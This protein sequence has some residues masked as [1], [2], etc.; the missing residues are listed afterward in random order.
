MTVEELVTKLKQID[1]A[2]PIVIDGKIVTREDYLALA[3]QVEALRDG[4]IDA[5]KWIDERNHVC[6]KAKDFCDTLTCVIEATPQQ[7]LAQ[8]RVEAVESIII[9]AYDAGHLNDFGGGNV[10]WWQDYIR[11]EL[12]A[13]C[14][15]YQSQIDQYAEQIRQGEVE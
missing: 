15:F 13:A 2:G 10:G 11:S 5:R 9:D 3:A 12:A 7:H 14:D 1:A 4:L 6:D 8:I